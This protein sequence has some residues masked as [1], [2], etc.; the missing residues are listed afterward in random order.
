VRAP[1]IVPRRPPSHELRRRHAVDRLGQGR[2]S[3]H[4][5]LA[6][7]GHQKSVALP[8]NGEDAPLYGPKPMASGLLKDAFRQRA[9]GEFDNFS[10]PSFTIE[11]RC[12]MTHHLCTLIASRI[13]E[14]HSIDVRNGRILRGAVVL[15]AMPLSTPDLDGRAWH[16]S[17]G[18]EHTA[19][20]GLRSQHRAASFAR[21]EE[22][23]GLHRHRL[24]LG[25]AATRTGDDGVLN[26]AR[27]R[28]S[29]AM[30]RVETD[31]RH[32]RW[33]R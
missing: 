13:D 2:L 17:V 26:H 19:V 6:K 20:A 10:Q 29:V 7:L 3:D 22:L 27:L 5:A 30:A 1:V 24:A 9:I 8:Q 32:S 11:R 16:R 14:L 18:A 21:V 28:S 4:R 33:L 12:A 25:E 23:T 15:S 31:S